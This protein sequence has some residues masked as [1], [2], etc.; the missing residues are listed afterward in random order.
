M[1]VLGIHGGYKREEDN[2]PSEFAMHDGAAV[3]VRDGE[4]LAAIEEE[5]LSRIKHT[6]CFPFRAIRRCLSI[7]EI[8]ASEIDRIA[9]NMS[10]G[11]AEA[12]DKVAL[13]DDPSIP[14]LPPNRTRLGS[15]LSE[16]LDSDVHS[17]LRFC[18]HHVAHAWSAFLPSGLDES[19]VV[20]IDGDGDGCSGM[21]L[22]GKGRRLRIIRA[23]SI[24]QSLGHL[25]ERLIRV[26]GY[27]RFDEYKA[28][29]LAPYGDPEVYRQLFEGSYSLLPDGDY[30]LAQ[31]ELWLSALDA[32]GLVANARRAGEPCTQMHMDFMAALQQTLERIIFHI[33]GGYQRLTKQ[34]NLC[35]AG[36]VAHNCSMNGKILYSGLFQNV[37][38]QPAAHDAGGALGAALSVLQEESKTVLA[39]P[40]FRHLFFGSR[41]DLERPIRETLDAWGDWLAVRESKDIAVDT[42]KLLAEGHVVG[43]VQGRSEFGPRSLGNRSILADPRPAANKDLINEMVKKREQFRPFAPSVLEERVQDYFEVPSNHKSFPFMIFVLRVQSYAQKLLGAVTH[44][45][46]TARVQTVSEGSNPVFWKLIHEFEKVTGTPVLLNTSFNNNAE[47][48]VDSVNDAVVC[49]LTTGIN[50]LVIDNLIV[51]KNAEIRAA[52]ILSLV[53]SIPRS[54]KLVRRVISTGDSGAEVAYKIES[55]KSRVFGPVEIAISKEMFCLLQAADGVNSVSALLEMCRVDKRTPDWPESEL[56]KLWGWRSISLT[57]RFDRPRPG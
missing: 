46:G 29:A 13:L 20:S 1:I 48:I 27:S 4:I 47:P 42:A 14:A 15:T 54:R 32:A 44:V 33:V 40:G 12:L 7:S 10:Q 41:A 26:V 36:G 19:L 37:F 34:R 6:N 49:F 53:P 30:E 39:M 11:F 35:L 24:A 57:P 22:V 9:V 31:P 16:L 52:S 28:M 38:V 55:T 2:D 5:R 51:S 17:K 43:W 21:I 25:Y 18:H 8:R 3:L 23:F 50:T 45:D 56:L